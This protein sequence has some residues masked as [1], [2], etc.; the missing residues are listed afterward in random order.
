MALMQVEQQDQQQQE[1]KI[2]QAQVMDLF[3]TA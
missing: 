1:E 2:V 3:P